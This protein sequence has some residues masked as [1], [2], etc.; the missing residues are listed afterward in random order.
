M[1]Y[2][3][4]TILCA[5]QGRD[6]NSIESFLARHYGVQL[7]HE[8]ETNRFWHEELAGARLF[9]NVGNAP[10]ASDAFFLEGRSMDFA[11]GPL[12]AIPKL[13]R[14]SSDDSL[15]RD[16]QARRPTSNLAPSA[17]TTRSRSA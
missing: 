1:D 9:R 17:V 6:G 13:E 15:P 3:N 7:R 8:L 12:E 4:G 10:E 14:R 5:N 11:I 16:R 2:A